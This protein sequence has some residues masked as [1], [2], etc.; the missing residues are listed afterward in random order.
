MDRA[1]PLQKSA[2]PIEKIDTREELSKLANV[3]HDTMS[4]VKKIEEKASNEIKEKLSSGEVSINQ[5]Y[6][7]IKKVM[8]MQ[9]KNRSGKYFP[10][11]NQ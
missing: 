4:K 3:S 11:L 5:A 10:D 2:N 7:E 8:K 9:T 6:R 1:T